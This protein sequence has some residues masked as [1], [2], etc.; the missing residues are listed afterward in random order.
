MSDSSFIAIDDQDESKAQHESGLRSIIFLFKFAKDYLSKILFGLL[1]ILLYACFTM[2]SGYFMGLLV[3]EGLVQKNWNL[4]IRYACIILSFEVLSFSFNYFG[5][6]ILS[7]NSSHMIYN[8]RREL[9]SLLPRLPLSLLDRWPEGRVVTRLTH[10]VET[11][12]TFFTGSLARLS[13]ALFLAF[14]SMVAMLTT[15]LY[16]GLIIIVSMIP[17]LSIVLLT[18][19]KVNKLTRAMSKY[20][21][22]INSK[23]SE[24]IDGLYIMRSFGLES[25]SM[26]QFSGVVKDHVDKS[27]ETNLFYGWSRPLVSFLC[28][29]PLILLVWFGGNMV[30][31][32]SI[33]IAIFV[34]FLRYSER[35]FMPVMMLF[36][37]IHVILQAF[38]NA[39]RVANFLELK[40]ENEF[41]DSN[42]SENH[43]IHGEVNFK[44][45]WMTY[46]KE[47]KWSLKDVSF[48][49]EVGE[50]IG[51]VGAT[52]SGKTTMISVLSR[53]YDYQKGE[54]LIDGVSIKDWNIDNLRSQIGLVSQDV[55]LF[56][57]T[58]RDNLTVNPEITDD[59]I[60][61]IAEKT[62]L[63]FVLERNQIGLYDHVI[64]GGKNFSAG[65][66]QIISL[67]RVCLLSPRILILDEATANIDPFYEKLL[68]DGVS[69]LMKERTSF[70]IA[71]RLDTIKEC[72]R[73]LVFDG[74]ELVE[75][76][77]PKN[78]EAKKGYFYKLKT[79]PSLWVD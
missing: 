26:D 54:I 33:T 25:W 12:E 2:F 51:I 11:V 59:Y 69:F 48:K 9:F 53:L 21:S 63:K 24:Y 77:T 16:L 31:E 43:L 65:E 36:R 56:K 44:N 40:T 27:L 70:I 14:I 28:G 50:N 79:D 39:N 67:T 46:T 10:D 66:K 7:I 38:T 29:L 37:E 8:M 1:L 6:K 34:A 4:S 78:L 19:S 32:G 15:D 41:F 30:L 61:Y 55:T 72:N 75:F 64:D 3:G 22:A 20:S 57:G 60:S 74:G 13:S 47:P 68:H 71:H 35:F 58:L 5:R 17:A 45:V 76:D 62:G 23:L 49:T 52:G 73:L 18:R 42:K